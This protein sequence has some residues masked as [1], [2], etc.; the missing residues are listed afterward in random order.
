MRFN[1]ISE[2]HKSYKGTNTFPDP[3][4][5]ELTTKYY[6]DMTMDEL[7]TY[8]GPNW[9]NPD[10]KMIGTPG[11]TPIEPEP[12]EP[13]PIE[14]KPTATAIDYVTNPELLGDMEAV[15]RDIAGFDPDAYDKKTLADLIAVGN[16]EPKT[17]DKKYTYSQPY[18]AT[19]PNAI[20]A[21]IDNYST[22]E[23]YGW[24]VRNDIPGNIDR[25]KLELE[26]FSN[27]TG[28]PPRAIAMSSSAR[29]ELNYGGTTSSSSVGQHAGV[30]PAP[31]A[32]AAPLGSKIKITGSYLDYDD[33]DTRDTFYHEI[34]HHLQMK[35]GAVN[36]KGGQRNQ[37]WKNR[38]SKN[39]ILNNFHNPDQRFDSE[40]RLNSFTGF[41]RGNYRGQ[42]FLAIADKSQ[43]ADGNIDRAVWRK[44]LYD[45][46]VNSKTMQQEPEMKHLWATAFSN[47]ATDPNL[48]KHSSDTLNRHAADHGKQNYYRFDPEELGARALASY[49]TL[50]NKSESDREAEFASGNSRITAT[51]FKHIKKWLTS[52][53]VING[54]GLAT[55]KYR[56]RDDTATV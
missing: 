16:T 3:D 12:I 44:N 34:W 18:H 7:E 8:P 17:R 52:L 26:R 24:R 15:K 9:E 54:V 51:T 55:N 35:L 2:D 39:D 25:V 46:I 40:D 29:D 22:T 11:T 30:F 32:P 33:E 53:R 20:A 36:A 50:A 13:E 27:A 42:H 4:N 56:I 23:V 19:K 47:L 37:S 10:L 38:F 48:L 31:H 21:A 41:G 43:N 14:K 49:V 28:I 45:N 6:G 1:D 5:K